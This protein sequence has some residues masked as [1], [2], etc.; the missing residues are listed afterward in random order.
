MPL[1][2][3][4]VYCPLGQSIATDAFTSSIR[5]APTTHGSAAARADVGPLAL[6]AFRDLV[7]VA[8]LATQPHGVAFACRA[9]LRGAL[10]RGLRP[11]QSK[12]EERGNRGDWQQ[13]QPCSMDSHDTSLLDQKAVARTGLPRMKIDASKFF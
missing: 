5:S 2:S 4:P 7:D 6:H 13:I 10:R 12:A 8:V 3:L 9:L 1:I 11:R